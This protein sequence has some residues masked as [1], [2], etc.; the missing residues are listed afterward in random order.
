LTV[1][2]NNGIFDSSKKQGATIINQFDQENPTSPNKHKRSLFPL[3]SASLF[4]ASIFG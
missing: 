2:E 4:D 3:P 1:L